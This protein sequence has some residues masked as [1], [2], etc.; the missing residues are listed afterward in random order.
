MESAREP[1]SVSLKVLRLSRPSF[2]RHFPLSRDAGGHIPQIDSRHTPLS[3]D[4]DGQFI[5]QP[6]LTLPPA[7]GSAYVGETFS[8]TL[9]ANNELEN[10]AEK[11]ITSIKITA[12]MQTPSLKIPLELL[13]LDKDPTPPEFEPG[14][15]LQKIVR[16]ELRE[17]GNHVLAVSVSYSE[18]LLSSENSAA[19][20]RVRTFRKLYQFA[21][22]PC[23]TVRTKVSHIST[24][25]VGNG[26]FKVEKIERFALEAQLENVAD[27]TIILEKVTF[28]PKP[29][30]S[31]ISFNWDVIQPGSGHI[32]APILSPRDI[33]QVAFLVTPNDS[34]VG[35]SPARE[36]TK[37][38]RI[39]LGQ[40]HIHW[41]TAMGDSG[42]LSTGWLMTRRR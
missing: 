10:N 15:S 33:T 38:G 2:S 40:L 34:P 36:I 17:E 3:K 24:D 41:R 18:T 37:D 32:E 30:F 7:F 28:S 27:G 13:P 9:C 39:M 31:S 23:L 20:G 26:K 8:C 11:V 16:Y 21:A 19:S 1:H 42:Y 4:I 12:E 22:Q 35:P 29:F 14:K 25:S 5:L 6:L